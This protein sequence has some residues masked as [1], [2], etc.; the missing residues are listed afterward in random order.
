MKAPLRLPSGSCF[1]WSSLV[2]A[3]PRASPMAVPSSISPIFTRSSCF[4]SQ[5]WSV[6]SG[7][8]V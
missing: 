1:A 2:M 7:E 4:A 5:A 8:S 6:V 3:T